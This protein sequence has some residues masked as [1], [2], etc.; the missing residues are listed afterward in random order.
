MVKSDYAIIWKYITHIQK[1]IN[2][3]GNELQEDTK[4]LQEKYDEV[5]LLI[6]RH[7]ESKIRVAELEQ[8][9]SDQWQ[10]AINCA[11]EKLLSKIKTRRTKGSEFAE[12]VLQLKKLKEDVKVEDFGI[13]K[14][15]NMYETDLKG[16]REQIKEKLDIENHNNKRFWLGIAIGFALGILTSLAFWWIQVK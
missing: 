8:F 10:K 2:I 13:D 14:Y 11:I 3:H 7:K 15:E 5:Q 4:H 6:S 16:F 12:I 9:C 1:L